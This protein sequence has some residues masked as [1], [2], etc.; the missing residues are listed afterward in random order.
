MPTNAQC[1]MHMLAHTS[2][3]YA[4]TLQHAYAHTHT[5]ITHARTLQHVHACVHTC[6]QDMT[7]ART[8][9][10]AHACVHTCGQDMTHARPPPP[11]IWWRTES[12]TKPLPACAPP[13]IHTRMGTHIVTACLCPPPV[14][15]LLGRSTRVLPSLATGPSPAR[16]P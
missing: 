10:P 9:Q 13:P 15:N 2:M 11:L 14:R 7:H 5:S 3:A 12:S 8:L 6:G 1:N 4:R 16:Y